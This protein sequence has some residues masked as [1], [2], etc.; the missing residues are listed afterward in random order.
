M[1]EREY[2]Q[3][4]KR[5]FQ[6]LLFLILLVSLSFIY[7]AYTT[8]RTHQFYNHVKSN[9]RGWAGKVHKA[10]TELGFVP[11]P[12]SQGSEIMPIGEPVP[13]RYDKDGFRIPMKETFASTNNNPVILTLG[14]SFTY[15]A[16]THAENTFPYLVG[17][18]LG[19][20][21]KNAGVSSYGLSQMEIMAKLFIPSHKPDYVIVQYSPWLVDRAIRP[22][23][24]SHFGKFPNPYYA[25]ENNLEIKPPVFQPKIGELPIDEY[26]NSGKGFIDFLS[27]FG[28][29]GLPLFL[30]DDFHLTIF[31]L[32]KV[33]RLTDRPTKNRSAVIRHAYGEI[34][35][36]A[37]QN[38]A[39]MI[40][41]VLGENHHLVEIPIDLLPNNAKIVDAHKALLNLLPTQ[42][43][44][45]YQKR[46]SHW[47]GDPPSLVDGHPNEYAHRIIAEE[48]ISQI[49]ELPPKEN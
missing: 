12:N 9:Q 3:K 32:E 2:P 20:S 1:S 30:H 40:M 13:M 5:I 21:T 43:K 29:V 41:V 23:A 4:R 15:G 36:V 7:F 33:L 39:K 31:T 10:D 14:C 17:S 44:Q 42:D 6:I 19:G 46:Y 47:R 11:I 24:P 35:R 8:Y 34:F 18:H 45:S 22:F 38:G 16:A 25:G 48:I 27:F 28:N 37:E 49:V 26:R